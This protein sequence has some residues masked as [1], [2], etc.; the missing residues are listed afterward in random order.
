MHITLRFS[1]FLIY[2]FN[3]VCDLFILVSLHEPFSEVSLNGHMQLLLLVRRE[4]RLLYFCLDLCELLDAHIKH[5]LIVLR[6]QQL[7]L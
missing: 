6:A 7:T 3:H 1:E 4:P 2:H 5:V